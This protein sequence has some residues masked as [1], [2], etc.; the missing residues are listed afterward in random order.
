MASW[1][2]RV[3]AADALAPILMCEDLMTVTVWVVGAVGPIVGG[4]YGPYIQSQRLPI[5]KEA[6]ERLI[7]VTRIFV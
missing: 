4:S 7:Q 6:A 5:Y 3:R 1:R 2:M